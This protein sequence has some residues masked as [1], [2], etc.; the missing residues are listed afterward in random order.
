MLCGV[1]SLV[2]VLSIQDRIT[3]SEQ[4]YTCRF[5]FMEPYKQ[6]ETVAFW[7][8]QVVWVNKKGLLVIFA[9]PHKIILVIYQFCSETQ[10]LWRSPFNQWDMRNIQYMKGIGFLSC[11][12]CNILW[13]LLEHILL[14]SWSYS[15]FKCYDFPGTNGACCPHKC[16]CSRVDCNLNVPFW[17]EF[18]SVL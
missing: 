15:W 3:W 4:N 8:Q 14:A 11:V 2:K 12:M 7:T 17:L 6:K 1:W 10:T 9:F 13:G 5:C 18:H 16:V